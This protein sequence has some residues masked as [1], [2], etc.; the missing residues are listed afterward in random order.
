LAGSIA[1]VLDGF[2][3]KDEARRQKPKWLDLEQ[4]RRLIEATPGGSR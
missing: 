4:T 3:L 1:T 2:T